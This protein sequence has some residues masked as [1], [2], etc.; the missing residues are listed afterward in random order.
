MINDGILVTSAIGSRLREC[1]I[2]AGGCFPAV[3]VLPEVISGTDNQAATVLIGLAGTR[4]GAT[5]ARFC[6]PEG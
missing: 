6:S 3:D 5:K 1:H 4:S 2:D